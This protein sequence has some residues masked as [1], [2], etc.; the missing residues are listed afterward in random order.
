MFDQ[1]VLNNGHLFSNKV[2]GLG[3]FNIFLVKVNFTRKIQVYP[4]LLFFFYCRKWTLLICLIRNIERDYVWVEDV[5]DVIIDILNRR[6][7][8][9]GISLLGTGNPISH[10]T[11]AE[12]VSEVFY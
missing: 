1:Y 12:L 11:Y 5:A 8:E 9:N 4:I 3:F 2:I 10:S 7:N 6:N